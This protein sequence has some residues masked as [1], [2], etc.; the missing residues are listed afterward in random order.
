M[1]VGEDLAFANWLKLYGT[2]TME[3]YWGLDPLVGAT[4]EEN[5]EKWK[6]ALGQDRQTHA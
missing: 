5:T 2:I 6:T 4:Q 3:K 1:T